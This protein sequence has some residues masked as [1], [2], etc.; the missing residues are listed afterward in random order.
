MITYTPLP[1]GTYRGSGECTTTHAR[2]YWQRTD[3]TWDGGWA[4]EPLEDLLAR[5][6]HIGPYKYPAYRIVEA[7]KPP[8]PEPGRV[9]ENCGLPSWAVSGPGRAIKIQEEAKSRFHKARTRTVWCHNDECAIQSLAISKY[10][11]ATHKWP[12]TLAQF[13]AM[14]PLEDDAAPAPTK[15]I[16]ASRR[17]KDLVWAMPTAKIDVGSN[18]E[19]R[20]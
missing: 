1:C 16:R 11:L 3:G 6:R 5:M 19:S 8:A 17:A 10:G 12:V 7:E 2:L 9:C 13:R 15:R 4:V 14:N 20:A 18:L